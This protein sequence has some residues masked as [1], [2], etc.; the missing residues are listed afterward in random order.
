M[1]KRIFIKE[2]LELKP[3]SKQTATDSFY[4]KVCNDVK[5]TITTSRYSFILQQ[6]LNKNGINLLACFL[7]SYLE[8]LVSETNIWK[9]FVNAHFRLYKK[10]L[11]FYNLDEYYED[12]VNIQDISFLI[13]YFICTIQDEDFIDPFNEF[14]A[15]IAEE[16]M[17]VF[18]TAWEFAPEN[19]QLKSHYEIDENEDDYFVA[20]NL[21]D[22]ILFET[23]LFYPDSAYKLINSELETIEDKKEDDNL[24][25]YIYENRDHALHSTHTHL[26]SFT[27][28]E[29]A[30]EILSSGHALK[31]D[32]LNTSKKITGLFLYKGQDESNIYIEHIASG[33]KFDVT[34]KSFDN[35]DWLKEVD[36][37]LFMGITK[38]K[39]KWWFSGVFFKE[40][41]DADIILDEKNSLISRAAVNFLDHQGSDTD[42]LLEK[43]LAAF[44]QF[45]NNSQIAFLP[46]EDIECFVKEYNDFFNKTLNLTEK[47]IK[48]TIQ[49]ANEDGYFG[50]EMEPI[51][52]AEEFESGL[53]FFNPKSGCEIAMSVNSAFPSASNP[54]YDEELSDEHIVRLL[55][56]DSLS[57]ELAMFCIDNFKNKL[58]FFKERIGK[59]YLNDIDFLLRFWKADNYHTIPSISYT[60]Q[61]E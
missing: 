51:N 7:T 29:W 34:K 36:E 43:H 10:Q 4:L 53:V 21:I 52:F 27:G 8:D 55:T 9:S 45:N 19:N 17:E 37:I 18:D 42:E 23:Y 3:Y 48:E 6:Y 61:E 58:P 31:K 60:G 49:R 20:R 57:T 54:F 24:M 35:S 2:W 11:P 46:S 22:T 59:G 13:W 40:S 47:Q 14:I 50:S 15:G 44:M 41:F 56:D 32:F 38:W 25:L 39:G 30:S 33:K 1:N 5:K 12:E 28:K 16:I 26:L